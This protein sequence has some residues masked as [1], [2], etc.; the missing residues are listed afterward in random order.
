MVYSFLA[1]PLGRHTLDNDGTRGMQDTLTRPP[2]LARRP[3]QQRNWLLW[4]LVAALLLVLLIGLGALAGYFFL[5]RERSTEWTWQD[6]LLGV[7]IT[8]VRPD[9]AVITLTGEPVAPVVQEALAAGEPDSAYSLL[10]NDSRLTDTERLGQL[11]S[12]ARAFEERGAVDLAALSYQ[13]MHSLAALSPTL[14]D[15]ERARASAD[16]A[17]GWMRLGKLDGA[18]PSLAQAEALARYSSL[19]APVQ[20]QE[21]AQRLA[22]IYQEAGMQREAEEAARL[23]SQPQPLPDAR[24]AVGP[25]LPGFQGRFVPSQQLQEAEEGRKRQTVAFI[26]AWDT[27]GGENVEAARSALAGALLLEDGVRQAVFGAEMQASPSLADQAAVLQAKIDWLTTKQMIASGAMGMNLVPEWELAAEQI[28]GELR[29]S[30]DLLFANYQQQ[31]AQLPTEAEINL[32]R[33][34]ALREALL[35]GRLGLYPGYAEDNL[36]LALHEAQ[37]A[38]ADLT[39]L[40]V[41]DEPWGRGRVFR[42]SEDFE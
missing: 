6:P 26:E 17:A 7:D 16:A 29:Q 35:M 28:A 38:I 41:V 37:A 24:R 23:L 40:L 18:R 33:S 2:T 32:A 15:Y 27:T 36:T 31:A 3:A 19:L 34:E 12:V 10:V 30:Y 14:S 39:T 42:L 25:F 4:V 1:G 20:R 5:T 21:I 8:R 13:Q 9:I 22:Q 11:L